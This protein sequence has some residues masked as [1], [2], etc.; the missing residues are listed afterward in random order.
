MI[1]DKIYLQVDPSEDYPDYPDEVTW[2]KDKIND[3]DVEYNRVSS[4]IFD[5]N[6]KEVQIGD[7]V[8][9]TFNKGEFSEHSSEFDVVWAN[10]G[11]KVKSRKAGT[12]CYLGAINHYVEIEV[13][14]RFSYEK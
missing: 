9:L 13:L 4:G 14:K 5:V 10:A 2:C 6:N 1:P 12:E 7:T 8:K 11:F 3:Y